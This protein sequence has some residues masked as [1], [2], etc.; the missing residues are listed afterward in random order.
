MCNSLVIGSL[1]TL[2]VPVWI[3]RQGMALWTMGGHITSQ[4]GHP[5]EPPPRKHELYTAAVGT[6]LRWIISRGIALAVNLFPQGRVAVIQKFKHWLSVAISYALAA[7]IFVLTL[8]VI[9]LLFGLLLEL[10]LVIPLRVPLDQT[11][12]H[13]LWQDWARGVL[14]TKIA[15]ALTLMG[16]DW[17]LKRAI[18]RAYRDGLRDI[19]LKFIIRELATPC[20][21]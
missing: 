13:S 1:I 21:N 20:N 7:V 9:P 12:V 15:C 14:C 16:T 17:S 4:S 2:T 5:E 10:V 19:D 6:Y 8:G 18:E 3:G 11:P